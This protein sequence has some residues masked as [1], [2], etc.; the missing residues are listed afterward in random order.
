MQIHAKNGSACGIQTRDV[1]IAPH[2]SSYLSSIILQAA[3]RCRAPA[4][5]LVHENYVVIL[6]I[7]ELRMLGVTAC[8]APDA[9]VRVLHWHLHAEPLEAMSAPGSRSLRGGLCK[10]IQT[11]QA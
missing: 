7:K 6:R 4:A 9:D 10:P 11:L 3:H 2:L 5:S 8:R 1:G